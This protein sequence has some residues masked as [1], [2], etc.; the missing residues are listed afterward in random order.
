MFNKRNNDMRHINLKVLLPCLHCPSLEVCCVLP[1][2]PPFPK[3]NIISLTIVC[4]L[5]A[6]PTSSGLLPL[7]PTHS[8]LS[9]LVIQGHPPASFLHHLSPHL[10]RFSIILLHHPALPYLG[11]LH[12]YSFLRFLPNH[13]GPGLYSLCTL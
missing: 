8:H 6:C 4:L 1:P 5:P 11:S 2:S 3:W 10:P 7:L 12:G 13:S 9:F